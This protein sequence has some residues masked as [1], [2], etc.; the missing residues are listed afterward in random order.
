MK[1]Q[2]E[3]HDWEIAIPERFHAEFETKEQLKILESFV[4]SL[5]P[6][7]DV[8]QTANLI[9]IMGS[10]LISPKT[11]TISILDVALME[12]LGRGMTLINETN[13]LLYVVMKV[14]ELD[15]RTKPEGNDE[16]KKSSLLL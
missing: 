1:Y 2:F 15:L 16:P 14:K 12:M 3:D 11:Y 4:T 13:L 6:F 5:P 7:A 9:P 8:K 10:L